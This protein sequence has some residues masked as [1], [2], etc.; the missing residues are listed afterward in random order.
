VMILVTMALIF[1]LVLYQIWQHTELNKIEE[2]SKYFST[3]FTRIRRL[4]SGRE[5]NVHRY[6]LLTFMILTVLLG[7]VITYLALQQLVAH[8]FS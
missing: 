6:L 8:R 7:A 4:K 5:A 2:I 3:A 1:T